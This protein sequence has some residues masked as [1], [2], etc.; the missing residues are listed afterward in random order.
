MICHDAVVVLEYAQ[1]ALRVI[2][3]VGVVHQ[4]VGIVEVVVHA[5]GKRQESRLFDVADRL[6]PR[7]TRAHTAA[8]LMVVGVLV[9][10]LVLVWLKEIFVD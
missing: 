10:S 3:T 2:F 5:V 1:G 8:P 7:Q 4:F 6:R 9:A